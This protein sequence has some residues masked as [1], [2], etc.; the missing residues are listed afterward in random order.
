M[1]NL[2]F[3]S[4]FFTATLFL[5]SCSSDD[6]NEPINE[7]EVITT[8]RIALTGGSTP[9]NLEWKQLDE[10]TAPAITVTGDLDPNT[11]YTS[12]ITVLNELEDPAD[13]ITLEI[14][15]EDE[16]HQFFYQV[17]S[18]LNI[19]NLTYLDFDGNGNPVGVNFS[20]DTGDTSSGNFTVTLRHE[21]NKN[22]DGVSEGNIANAG[23]ETDIEITFP[24]EIQ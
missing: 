24:L 12:V 9:I 13:N 6:G 18:G 19:S 16:E 10:S 7:E 22:A 5:M 14:I 8:V 11:T 23:G 20:F 1:K 4:I 15:E 21:P 3:L 2:K 17:S